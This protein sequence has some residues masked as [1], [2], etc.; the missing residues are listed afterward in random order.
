MDFNKAT[1]AELITAIQTLTQERDQATVAANQAVVL[2]NE[3]HASLFNVDSLLSK[4]PFISKE[5]KFIK[6]VLWVISNWKQI[7]TLLE[8]IFA[9]LQTWRNRVSQLQEQASKA[10]DTINQQPS[11]QGSP[12]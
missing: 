7:R 8:D 2:A 9:S 1:K 5:G 6:T 12:A 4:A 10:N 3:F 11:S